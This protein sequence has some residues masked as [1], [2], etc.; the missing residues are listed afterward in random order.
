MVT[1]REKCGN[2][3]DFMSNY[4]NVSG[5]MICMVAEEGMVDSA[6]FP[7]F[8][9]TPLR[10]LSED[11]VKTPDDVYQFIERKIVAVRNLKDVYTCEEIFTYI[12]SG[13]VVILIEGLTK[14]IA[15]GVQGF[16]YRSISAPETE[17]N[18]RGSRE[19]F[20]EAL[21]I[22]ISMVRRRM[23]SPDLRFEMMSIGKRSHTDVC[24]A[25]I[26][27]VVSPVLLREVRHKL[28]QIELDEVLESGYLQPFLE[29][30]P[31]AFF[32]NVGT[33]ERP[34]T[35]VAKIS[36]GRVA[37]LVDGTPFALITPYLFA[38]NF[39]NFDD[40]CHKSYYATFV[41]FVKY[42]SFFLAIFLPGVYVALSTFHPE[43]FA[44]ELIFNI[45]ATETKI[46]L[47]LMVEALMIHF[48]YE[49]MREAGL[50]MP[51]PMGH[52]VSIVGA[53]VIGDTAVSAGLVSPPMVLVSALTAIAS[54]VVPT[55]YS[56]ISVFRLIFIVL[57]G[58]MG[59]Y[60]IALG[61]FFLLIEICALNSFGV[62]YL[63]P[64]SPFSLKA[65]RDVLVRASWRKLGKNALN[66]A[67]LNGANIRE[68]EETR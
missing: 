32:S 65:M 62:P 2:S 45:A 34:D 40:Y 16:K 19:G 17:V 52:A 10:E 49:I 29:D 39:Q 1:L 41:R 53:L 68:G 22:N 21:R 37:V 60:G 38:E 6:I 3:T 24:I 61:I 56:P 4:L 43:I 12:M 7:N 57:G 18:V 35:L 13:F 42:A 50:R 54:Y 59:L 15:I 63:A 8:I 48:I 66:I 64:I 33:T 28:K 36:E 51:A 14:G 58:T 47:P 30:N 31:H 67:K 20:V 27:G 26:E 55:L 23:K 46:P 9:S 25:Y 5:H 11:E 44:Y